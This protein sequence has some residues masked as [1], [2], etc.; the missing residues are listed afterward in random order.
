MVEVPDELRELDRYAI[1]NLDAQGRWVVEALTVAPAAAGEEDDGVVVA[2]G[3]VLEFEGERAVGE[4]HHLREEG[5]DGIAAAV[6]TGELSAATRKA[7]NGVIGD[8]RLDG[9]GVAAIE[10][11][12]ERADE[13]GVRVSWHGTRIRAT[14]TRNKASGGERLG[15]AHRPACAVLRANQSGAE[16]IIWRWKYT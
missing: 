1:T 5:D 10:G 13:G 15:A 6:L 8:G 14:Y 11:L 12:E 16:R 4:H 3:D 9:R 2:G 7:P